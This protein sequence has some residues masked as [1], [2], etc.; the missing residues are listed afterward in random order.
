MLGVTKPQHHVQLEF[1]D[2]V[3]TLESVIEGQ[4]CYKA[5][6]GGSEKQVKVDKLGFAINWWM[7]NLQRKLQNTK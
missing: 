5:G 2:P 1:R 6:R 3:L 7:K 4:G